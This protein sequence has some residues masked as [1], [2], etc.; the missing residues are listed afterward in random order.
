MEGA[1]LTER[2][3]H[4]SGAHRE[5]LISD[6]NIN[7]FIC[8]LWYQVG[9][10]ERLLNLFFTVT[11]LVVLY[12]CNSNHR[13]QPKSVCLWT[14]PLVLIFSPSNLV[15]QNH[16]LKTFCELLPESGGKKLVH[17]CWAEIY[18][19]PRAKK[20]VFISLANYFSIIEKWFFH[21]PVRMSNFYQL[22]MIFFSYK[23]RTEFFMYPNRAKHKKSI[24]WNVKQKTKAFILGWV[25]PETIIEGSKL[26][27]MPS[28]L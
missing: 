11:I 1:H 8:L 6:R 22:N 24:C 20:L 9:K 27:S 19:F 26:F 16:V 5:K 17:V 10:P 4:E 12:S 21:S 7:I 23:Q 15:Y 2:L 3:K 25:K 13:E 14:F 28:P 18:F